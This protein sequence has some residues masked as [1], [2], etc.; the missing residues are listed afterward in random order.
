LILPIMHVNEV[1][2]ACC[3][4]HVFTCLSSVGIVHTCHTFTCLGYSQF[5]I[6]KV[7]RL[8]VGFRS[9]FTGSILAHSSIYVSPLSGLLIRISNLDTC[10]LVDLRAAFERAFDSHW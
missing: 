3:V 6:L 8:Q 7:C 1:I 10:S 2:D 4:C 9:T 5:F